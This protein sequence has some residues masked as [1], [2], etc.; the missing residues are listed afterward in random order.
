MC[1]LKKSNNF[2]PAQDYFVHSGEVDG[3]MLGSMSVTQVNVQVS[4]WHKSR[5]EVSQGSLFVPH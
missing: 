1:L 5:S 3:L 4:S 2:P